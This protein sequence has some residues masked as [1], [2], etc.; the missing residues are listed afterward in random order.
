MYWH[1][2]QLDRGKQASKATI[3]KLRR[4]FAM[5]RLCMESPAHLNMFEREDREDSRDFFYYVP[6]NYHASH[7][8][9][10][11]RHHAVVCDKP[12]GVGMHAVIEGTRDWDYWF[13]PEERLT[14]LL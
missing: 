2:F 9:F 14:T 8:A 7:K 4:E 6:P 10:L 12:S 5:L 1:K 13:G 11:I 3:A